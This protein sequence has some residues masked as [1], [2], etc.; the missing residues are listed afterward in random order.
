MFFYGCNH[1]GSGYD[2]FD[3]KDGIV[4]IFRWGFHGKNHRFFLRF[5]LND[6]QFITIKVKEGIYA[7][8]IWI[9]EAS[10][11]IPLT[12]IDENFMSLQHL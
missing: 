1:V 3:I 5:L 7:R 11:P 2:R 6:I 8:H 9:L 10:Q 12:H 4:C